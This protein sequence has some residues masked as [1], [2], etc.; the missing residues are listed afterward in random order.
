MRLAVV[1]K[2]IL[3]LCDTCCNDQTALSTFTAAL[4]LQLTTF[5]RQIKKEQIDQILN[6][7]FCPKSF[8]FQVRER[9][10][11]KPPLLLRELYNLKNINV[12]SK[13]M[14]GNRQEG[15]CKV[16]CVFVSILL[17]DEQ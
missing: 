10:L 15:M 5:Y 2:N 3:I 11:R 7:G 13:D 14:R 6:C 8:I 4:L 1:I 17:S 16:V 12:E 9:H